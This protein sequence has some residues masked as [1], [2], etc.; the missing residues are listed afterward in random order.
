MSHTLINQLRF[1]R[2][3][4]ARCLEGISD[5]DARHR[6]LPMNCI[7][8]MVGHMADQEQNYFVFFPQGKV[9]HPQLNKLVGFGH[10]ATTPPL[11]EMWQVYHEII[12]AADSFL[13]T[14]TPDQLTEYPEQS[15][16]AYEE[17]WPGTVTKKMLEQKSVRSPE[18]FGT[19][20]QRTTYHYFFHT[21]EAHAV[22]QLLG[23]PYLPY[24]IGGMP[25]FEGYI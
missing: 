17:S 9:P 16:S 18:N 22:R 10:P 21:G 8:W 20:M 1:A 4:F 3:E 6:H 13:D 15:I 23:Q 25:D 11:D 7:S 24:I 12:T 2:S 19:R 5:Q 14:V